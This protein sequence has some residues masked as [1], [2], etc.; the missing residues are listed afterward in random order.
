MTFAEAVKRV[1]RLAVIAC[2]LE[3]VI[4]TIADTDEA[5]RMKR[6]RVEELKAEARAIG[7]ETE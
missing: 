2:E 7:A 4:A 1:R 3:L 5:K 6:E